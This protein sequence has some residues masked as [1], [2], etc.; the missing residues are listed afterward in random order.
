MALIG[1]PFAQFDVDR[2]HE[3]V[4]GQVRV[5]LANEDCQVFRHPARLDD[6][7]ADFFQRLGKFDNIRSAILPRYSRPR[8]HA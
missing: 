2:L 5:I 1:P 8:V 3:I 4:R 6:V 7:D